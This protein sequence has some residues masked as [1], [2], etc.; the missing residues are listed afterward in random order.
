MYWATVFVTLT[1]VTLTPGQSQKSNNVFSCKCISS[2]IGRSNFKLCSCIVHI[3][4][5][6]LGNIVCD[7]GP[8]SRS[9]NVFS[10]KCISSLTIGRSNLLQTLEVLSSHWETYL[11]T[12]PLVKVKRPIMHFLVNASPKL[13]DLAISNCAGT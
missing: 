12:L 6:V 1:H 2:T 4:K 11:V 3:L 10:C 7:L 13:L 8:R 9:N 5:R